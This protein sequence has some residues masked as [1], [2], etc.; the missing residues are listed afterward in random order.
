LGEAVLGVLGD[1]KK[2]TAESYR[3]LLIVLFFL[4]ETLLVASVLIHLSIDPRRN[5]P[6]DNM[7]G[8]AALF[9]TAGQLVVCFFLRRI[10]RSLAKFGWL[11][12]LLAFLGMML[13]PAVH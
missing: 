4:F 5:S 9:S 1:M 13:L 7:A 8:I 3:H 6:I 12:V 2:F 11:T 10:A